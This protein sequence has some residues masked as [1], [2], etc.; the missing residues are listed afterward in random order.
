MARYIQGN[1]AVE[2]QR[3]QQEKKVQYRETKKVVYRKKPLPMKEKLLY[4]TIVTIGA[5]IASIIVWQYV[6]IYQLNR[7]MVNKQS[8]IKKIEVENTGLNQQ[9]L[10]L[11]SPERLKAE[12]KNADSVLK[13]R[14]RPRMSQ[15][16]NRQL[17]I[18]RITRLGVERC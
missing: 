1:L 18:R 13:I 12:A 3:K 15:S 9:Y 8:E 14:I 17:I 4:L 10:V 11:V 5:A 7:A 16:I 2:P 6:S